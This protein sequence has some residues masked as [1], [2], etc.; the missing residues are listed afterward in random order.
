[1][2]S[3][4]DETRKRVE[5]RLHE[6]QARQQLQT[7]RDLFTSELSY[8]YANE[9]L[10]IP[11]AK[12][13]ELMYENE[14]PRIIA[15]GGDGDFK[16]IYI[17]LRGSLSLGHERTLIAKLLPNLIYAL[18]VFSNSDQSRWHFVNVKEGA[19]EVKRRLFRR[20]TIGPEEQLRTAIERIAMLDLSTLS[21][22]IATLSALAIQDIFDKAFDVEAVT[23]TFF[24]DYRITFDILQKD[25]KQQTNDETWA[26][27]Y[28]LQLLNRCMFLYFIQRK[29]WLGDDT[30]FLKT[31]WDTYKG[32]TTEQD[33]F[34]SQWLSMLFFRAFN[35]KYSVAYNQF[36]PRIHDI[37]MLAPF[38]NGGL[39]TEND[40][41]KKE[42]FVVSDARF[43]QIFDL[44]QRYNF[45]IAE[46]SPLDQEVA[47]DPEMIG[48]VYESLVNVSTELDERSDAG[49]FY[50]PRTEIDLMCR[51]ALVDYLT[52]H[53]GTEHKHV[54]YDAVFALELE[55]K[56]VAD[57]HLK[58]GDLWRRVYD[59]LNIITVIDPACGS[60]AFLVGMLSVLDDLMER[61][62]VSLGLEHSYSPYN[63]YERK[64]RIIGQS[65]YGVDVMEWAVHIAELRL[66]LALIVDAE[67][68]REDLHV[69]TEPLLPYFTFKVRC[70]D[71]LVQEVGG[72]KLGLEQKQMLSP[73]IKRRVTLLRQQKL[74]FYN[75]KPSRELH[76]KEDVQ[77]VERNLFK[78]IL[79]ERI[80]D[81]EEE[82]KRLTRQIEDVYARQLS[83]MDET[84]AHASTELRER[85]RRL[86]ERED[87]LVHLKRTRD[88]L[89]ASKTLPFVWDIAFGEIFADQQRF[90]IVIGNPPYLRQEHIHTPY[91]KDHTKEDNKAYKAKLAHAMYELF[92]RFFG[93]TDKYGKQVVTNPINQKSDLYIYFYLLGLSLLNDKGAFC[94][95][96]SNSWL[97][98]GYG[99][100]LQEFLL[101]HCH[102]KLV[103][104]N[105]TMRSF[106]SASVNTIIA[107]FSPPDEES[108][109]GLTQTAYFVMSRVPFEQLLS[110]GI[111]EAIESAQDRQT[112]PAYRVFP[113]KQQLLLEDGKVPLVEGDDEEQ[114][115]S[116]KKSKKANSVVATE[117]SYTGNKWGGKYLR[118]PDI[119]WTIMEKGKDKLVR[120]GD[121]AEVRR[122]VTTGANEF[123]YL[124]E[125]K[126]RQW[127]I[128]PG[129]LVPVIKSPRECRSILIDPQNLKSKL[130]MCHKSK[131][132]L[133]GT[134]ALEYIKWGESQAFQKRPSCAGRAKWWSLSLDTANSIFVKEANETSAV[135]FNPESY[136]V[137]CRLYYA[138]LS[139]TV[140]VYLNSA[141]GAMS[142]EIYN[143]AGL[144]E[145]AR[146]LMVA[147]YAQI[148]VLAKEQKATELALQGIYALSPRRLTDVQEREWLNIDTIIFDALGLTS[149]E[150]DAVYDAVISLVTSR[151]TKAKSVS[152]SKE[153]RKRVETVRKLT[154]VWVGVPDVEEEEE[155]VG[156]FSA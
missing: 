55:D 143:R 146:S 18:F 33:T 130:F 20:I 75:N 141:L 149:G 117:P 3:T 40:L 70:G 32:V 48:T 118:A 30:E 122:G 52:N 62:I 17:R 31:F 104:D 95:I 137:D 21:T 80:R 113:I 47:V 64:K 156:G 8:E 15:T 77:R 96:T 67:Y 127:Q 49:I 37:L 128:E 97:D 5:H 110:P 24:R 138:D 35:N 84:L 2:S 41:D 124:D 50:T 63:A 34:V 105:E 12:S 123:F 78:D 43:A 103:L 133:K 93:Y 68:T 152:T 22:N 7:L 111:F 142:F 88:A 91:L 66:W 147:D 1:M 85:Q 86:V 44:L 107:R 109:W 89:G 11:D 129:F 82:N 4:V 6:L 131:A 116:G 119:Y 38:L 106:A 45:T 150:R 26:H 28:A 14:N 90:D 42:G 99:A 72:I 151:L 13:R 59:L 25:L 58:D 108:E 100:E 135:F 57:Q 154:G 71:S 10:N 87:E 120:L 92:P 54:L 114:E 76:T 112:D 139:P 65:L 148:P 132:E 79:A 51:L 144:G 155:A 61:A 19:G 36:P 83:L 125:A 98:V 136:P 81:I 126:V 134:R 56:E 69:R 9:R 94:F 115:Q 23:R 121:V 16:I 46:D 53:L 73:M 74:D 39:F 27:D 29:R 140:M 102:I 145:G 101:K 153:T 60:G